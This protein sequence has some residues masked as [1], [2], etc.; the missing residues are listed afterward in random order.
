MRHA[1][2]G[3][4][5][6]YKPLHP[7][8]GRECTCLNGVVDPAQI[9]FDNAARTYVDMAHLGVSHLS[10]WKTHIVPVRD[11]RGIGPGLHQ[12]IKMRCACQCGCVSRQ[13]I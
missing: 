6:S 7:G 5:R 8:Q 12:S 9:H 10:I 1:T 11:Q 2:A 4:E 13:I 3:L